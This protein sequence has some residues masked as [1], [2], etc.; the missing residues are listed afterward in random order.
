MIE[1]PNPRITRQASANPVQETIIKAVSE[2]LNQKI[3]GNLQ[4][5]AQSEPR[6]S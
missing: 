4:N 3:E 1:F 5:A 2:W 6:A